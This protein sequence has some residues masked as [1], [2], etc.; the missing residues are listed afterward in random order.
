MEHASPAILLIPAHSDYQLRQVMQGVLETTGCTLCLADD[1]STGLDLVASRQ[2]RLVIL[3]L[4]A[5]VVAPK[6]LLR[7]IAARNKAAQTL[8]ITGSKSLEQLI[9]LV[10]LDTWDYL[11]KP[12][13]SE[14]FSLAVYK[15]LASGG[16]R[17][18]GEARK[19]SQ[20]ARQCPILL[21]NSSKIQ[22]VKTIIRRMAPSDA[23]VLLLGESGTG[24]ELAARLLHYHSKRCAGP[25]VAVNC[26]AIP[27][28]LLESELFGHI[29][30]AFSGA[31]R[32]HQGKFQQAHQGTLFLDEV[33]ELP[34]ELQPKLLRAL[35]EHEV[36][37]VG[38]PTKL[39]DVRVVAATNCDLENLVAAGRFRSDL[40][41]RL[42][43]LPLKMPA[44]RDRPEDIAPLARSFLEQITGNGEVGLSSA[45]VE[46]LRSY[47]WP[48]NVR[49]LQNL[50]E[51]LA[52][53]NQ[54]CLIERE[55]LPSHLLFGERTRKPCVVSLPPEG[56][57]LREIERQ[58]IMQ[59]LMASSGNLTRAAAFLRVPRH[60]LAYRVNKYA[61]EEVIQ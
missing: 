22:R 39:V 3:D 60:I 53:L 32:D 56:F 58:A 27:P 30:G 57:P 8:L 55:D 35:Q 23:S 31:V 28:A 29:R 2:P 44:L 12:F 43:V 45:A 38:G 24:K 59:A 15:A 9:D 48:G 19:T 52:I 21:G 17:E 40:F 33:G 13:S 7:Q 1:V 54:K 36:S 41:Y 6:D 11:H 4:C 37:P 61:L 47:A 18:E 51:R 20:G 25:F 14:Q 16:T 10:H 49:E 34:P 42:A 26:A 5:Q 46:T 50:M